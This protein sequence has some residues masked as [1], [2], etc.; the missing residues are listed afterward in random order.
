M[1]DSDQDAF[2]I[3]ALNR[4]NPEAAVDMLARV[5]ERS[6]WLAVRL[7]AHRPYADAQELGDRLQAE[8]LSLTPQ[9]SLRL[10]AAHPEL[11]PPRPAAMTDASQAEQGRLALTDPAPALAAR[12]NVLNTAYQQRFGFPFVIAL[13]AFED[14]DRVIARFE[15]RLRNA[16]EVERRQ[17]LSEVVSVARARLARLTGADERVVGEATR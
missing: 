9:D 2:S 16:P 5:T 12:L 14:M 10:L 7:A 13:H 6:D 1:S 15:S 11:A 4:A 17:A 8:I 3:A